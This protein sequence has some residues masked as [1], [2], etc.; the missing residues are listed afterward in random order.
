M[1]RWFYS[2]GLYLATP[3]IL[4]RLL[5]RSRKLPAYRQRWVERF[6]FFK[7]PA[8]KRNGLWLHT[9]SVGEFL[10][11]RPLIKAFM[12]RNPNVPI[13][14]T[15]TTPTGS[16]Q[17]R[18][19]FTAQDVFHVYAPYDMPGAVQR[20]LHRVQPRLTL[21]METELWPNMLQCAKRKKSRVVVINARL[22]ERSALGYRKISALVK[23]ML[24]QVDV[25][26]CQERDTANRF[27]SLGLSSE[28]VS[29]TGNLKYDL[30]VSDS[31]LEQGKILR[32]QFGLARPVWI[33]GSTHRGEDQ[34][35]LDAHKKLLS[36]RP[37]A[38]LLL[39]PRHPER[40]D[41]VA[42]L[43][44]SN[45]FSF[46]RRSENFS[47]VSRAQ[48]AIVDSVGELLPMYSSADV[49][50]VAGS[51]IPRG[52]HNP[53]EPAAVGIPILTGPH[54]FNFQRVYENLL[55]RSAV[56]E[57]VDA[58]EIFLHLCALL[59]S[60]SERVE[61]NQAAHDEVASHQGALTATLALL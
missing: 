28:K 36:V 29:V 54:Y 60:E 43:S 55:A 32:L 4:L 11:A 33:A 6:G 25:M 57:C 7:I 24:S 46:S 10:A 9:V 53:I 2:F 47:G 51:L 41:E 30:Q 21:I 14:I 26:C 56:S 31:V 44:S 18:K 19:H 12:L 59:S 52:G 17:V 5:W 8:E 61:K 38:L 50:F 1:L 49:A 3:F 15:T 39:V 23:E 34:I 22:S 13:V 48:V 16:E 20:F 58:E 37:D 27:E 42:E 35:L 40:F 45:G